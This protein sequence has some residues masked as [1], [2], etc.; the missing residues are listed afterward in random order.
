MW[1]V[2]IYRLVTGAS[3]LICDIQKVLNNFG[4]KPTREREKASPTN[5]QTFLPTSRQLL[6]SLNHTRTQLLGSMGRKLNDRPIL[7]LHGDDAAH[8]VAGLHVL[9][10]LVDLVQRLAVGNEF[11]NLEITVEVIL[12]KTWKLRAALHTTKCTS[13]PY[14]SSDQLECYSKSVSGWTSSRKHIWGNL[15]LVEISCPAA[16]TPMIIDSPQPLWHAS[17]AARMTPTLPVQSKV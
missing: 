15:R 2:E 14:T 6:A 9:E 11:V 3:S 4:A 10:G 8:T 7:L 1:H 12:D 17:S 16:A 13:L 5:S